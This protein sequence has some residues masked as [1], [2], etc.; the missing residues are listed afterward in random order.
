[1]SFPLF[2]IMFIF[3]FALVIGTFI[4]VF[5]KGI[6]QWSKNNASPRLTV[7]ASVVAKRTQVGHHHGG[8]D[9]MSHSS[10]TN[11]FATFQV[12]SG[13]RME[14]EVKSTDFGMLVEGDYG[15]LSF[16]GTRFLGFERS[17]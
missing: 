13:D 1:M 15:A 6:G 11:Y 10:Y 17:R 5:V 9:G 7:S 12:E 2:N 8:N 4:A 14:L 3:V 16:Q